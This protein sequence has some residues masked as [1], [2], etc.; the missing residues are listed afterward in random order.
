[1]LF[2][3]FSFF[4]IISAAM[5][6]ALLFRL[7]IERRSSEVGILVAE[8]FSTRTISRLLL[9]EG[10]LLAVIGSAI[11]LLGA[12]AYAWL[13]LQGL[14]SWW[15][16][17]A[18]VPFLQLHI[19]TNSLSIGFL[20]SVAVALLSIIWAVH[21]LSR[22][23][24]HALLAGI[25]SSVTHLAKPPRR[26]FTLYLALIA[27]I[28][29]L[30]LI[31]LSVATEVLSEPT[32]FFSSG[33][34]LLVGSLAGL[35]LWIRRQPQGPIAGNGPLAIARLG[36]RN[37]GRYPRRS[38][39]TAGLIASATFILVTVGANRHQAERATDHKHSATGGFSLLAESAIGLLYDLNVTTG[40][41]SLNLSPASIDALAQS[42]VI[43]FRLRD[44][45]QASCLNLYQ[46]RS[47][48][49][50]GAAPK[51]IGRGGFKFKSTLAPTDDAEKENPW[52]LLNKTFPDGAIPAIG[53]YNTVRWLLHLG[54]GQD[55]A[56]TDQH[57]KTVNLRIV[58]MLSNSILQ[59]ELVIAESQFVSLFP[60]LTGYRFFLID[61][62]PTTANN[63]HELLE[64]D[65]SDFGFD[66]GSTTA[67][68]QRFL[69]VENT[70]LSVFQTLGGL[71]IVLGTF[72]LAAV[73]LRN[74]W[75]RQAEL[76]L[77]RAVGYRRWALACMV[78]AENT[79][80]LTTGLLAGT[81]SAALAV[82]P[83]AITTPSAIPWTSLA[84][85]LAI[86]LLTGTL[87]GTIALIPTLRSPLIPALRTE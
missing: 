63:L 87:A 70:Y 43:P 49:I 17:A 39:L 75:E 29:A 25:S 2:L 5:L 1:M 14:Q 37:A 26:R 4:L 65:L 67:Q 86:V 32:A 58:A 57:G 44:G 79:L 74:T 33:A 15:S 72:G 27:P 66:V 30:I 69:A 12:I 20:A 41:Q 9:A 10:A 8:G 80:L 38:L 53:D 82:A 11:G 46:A 19:S 24:P 81:I 18:N 50:L 6:V 52:R 21:G 3:G 76:A 56:I 62:P 83:H 45:D 48:R 13:M 47:P 35:A 22:T 28:C 7:G 71:G 54:L 78:L 59:G 77:L 42:Q 84:I 61:T 68:L 34:A 40:H 55:L 51:M 36:F 85:T 64:T 73:L 60:T 31:V 23:S 16:A